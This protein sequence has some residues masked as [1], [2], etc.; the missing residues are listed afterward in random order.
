MLSSGNIWQSAAT[1]SHLVIA[2]LWSKENRI[3][4]A[5]LNHNSTLIWPMHYIPYFI[6]VSQRFI[7]QDEPLNMHGVQKTDTP[8]SSLAK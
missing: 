1:A 8:C 3:S 7:I 6:E 5:I 2:K 4:L